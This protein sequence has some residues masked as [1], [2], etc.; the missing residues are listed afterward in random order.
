MECT[1][2]PSLLYTLDLSSLFVKLETEFSDIDRVRRLL[3][4]LRNMRQTKDVFNYV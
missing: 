1:K 3:A 4:K 2:N